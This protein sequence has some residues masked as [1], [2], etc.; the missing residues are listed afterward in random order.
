MIFNLT[1][2]SFTRVLAGTAFAAFVALTSQAVASNSPFTDMNG[3]WTGQGTI[4]LASGVKETIRCRA[5]YN[6]DGAGNSLQ[7]AL[8]CASDSYK[9]EL[10]SSVLNTNGAITGH[11]NERTNNVGGTI[12]GKGAPG[13]IQ[14]IAE[15]PFS[16]MLA[17]ST[18]AG[19]QSI[20][21]RSPGSQLSE[22]AISM[23]RK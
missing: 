21:I 14:V 22:V 12:S 5:T 10:Q 20:S 6:V 11:W 18:K 16:A 19:Q 2:K 4:A 3:S 13:R 15:G 8:R 7:L 9:F 23:S 1:Q 17:M